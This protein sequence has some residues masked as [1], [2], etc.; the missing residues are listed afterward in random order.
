MNTPP[1]AGG[2]VSTLAWVIPVSGVV[3]WV[4]ILPSTR[5]LIRRKADRL[6]S[7]TPEPEATDTT[8]TE[9]VK[10]APRR[11]EEDPEILGFDREVVRAK[12]ARTKPDTTD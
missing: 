4:L 7:R 1:P 10:S 2:L 6:T 3:L 12:F 5:S 9:P 8:S 11:R